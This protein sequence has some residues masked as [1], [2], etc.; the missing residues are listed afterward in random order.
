M[1]IH[2]LLESS[3][4]VG[5]VV[6]TDSIE[7]LI[8][9]SCI[10][11]LKLSKDV[12]FSLVVV[13]SSGAEFSYGKS[14]NVGM[15]A[16]SD[17]QYVFIMDNDTFVYNDALSVMI[18]YM[19]RHPCVGF[20]GGFKCGEDGRLLWVGGVHQG[21][22]FSYLSRHFF[23]FGYMLFALQRVVR[24]GNYSYGVRWT[25]RYLPGDMVSIDSQFCCLRRSCYDDV[26]PWDESF[27]AA[28]I[29]QDYSFRV[30]LHP[31]WFVSAC[32]ARYYHVG[33]VTRDKYMEF[34]TKFQGVD[35][36][37]SKWN[38]EAI[39]RVVD[40]GHRGKFKKWDDR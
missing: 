13:E 23:F 37:L 11:K 4:G 30:L 1:K 28:Y 15:A 22:I 34:E 27:R 20:C 33:R 12:N 31:W 21:S 2:R 9:R 17:C 16:L 18:S 7:A 5:V 32:P 3:N 25:T 26:G 35:V 38:R 10:A 36:Y 40:A 14:V 39:S 19:N 8:L 6:L 29:G 24:G